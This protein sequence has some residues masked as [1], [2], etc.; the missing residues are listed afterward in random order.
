MK[1]YMLALFCFVWIQYNVQVVNGDITVELKLISYINKQGLKNDK[2]CCD[3]GKNC[4]SNPCDPEITGCLS[5]II[6]SANCDIGRFTTK[7]YIDQNYISFGHTLGLNIINPIIFNYENEWKNSINV[8]LTVKDIDEGNTHDIIDTFHDEIKFVKVYSTK[9]ESIPLLRNWQG[10]VSSIKYAL[11]IYCSNNYYGDTCSTFCFSAGNQQYECNRNG[12]KVCKDNWYGDKCDKFCMEKDSDIDGH[13]RCDKNGDKIC[14]TNWYTSNCTVHCKENNTSTYKCSVLGDKKCLRFW[15]GPQCDVYCNP[16]LL[17]SGYYTCDAST[18]KKICLANWFG[19][20][21]SVFCRE[22]VKSN[23]ICNSYTGEK[24][25]QPNYYGKDCENYCKEEVGSNY[26]CNDNGGKKCHHHF[27]G[28]DC[29]IYVPSL[30]TSE[31][32]CVVSNSFFYKSF[33]GHF[34]TFSGG[35]TYQLT[36]D[37]IDNTFAVHLFTEPNCMSLSQSCKHSVNIYFGIV[38]IKLEHNNVKV[39]NDSISLP[40]VFKNILFEKS[41]FNYVVISGW[42]GVT[43]KWDGTS[44]YIELAASYANK[45]CGLCGNFNGNPKDDFTS[46]QGEMATSSET[47]ANSW[48]RLRLGEVCSKSYSHYGYINPV[49]N[50]YNQLPVVDKN[51]VTQICSVLYSLKFQRCNGSVDPSTFYN[52]CLED[53]ASCN[54]PFGVNCSCQALTEYSRTCAE[55]NVVLQWR[56][57]SLCYRSCPRDMIYSECDSTCPRTCKIKYQNVP[58]INKCIDGCVC[59][60]GYVKYN[61]TCILESECPCTHNDKIYQKGETIQKD[62][63]KC[64]CL[65]GRWNCT[66]NVCPGTCATYGDPHYKTFDGKW[67]DFNGICKYVLAQDWETHLFRVTTENIAC[68][69]T[70]DVSCA[71][72]VT[73]QLNGSVIV[74]NQGMKVAVEKKAVLLP[75]TGPGILIRK[76]SSMFLKVSTTIGLEILFDGSSRIYVTVSPRF[77]NKTRGLCGTFNLNQK[78]DFMTPEGIINKNEIAFGNAWKFGTNCDPVVEKRHPCEL[79]TQK[80]PVASKKCRKMLLSPFS[81]CH[82][83]VLPDP[84]IEACRFDV[85]GCLDGVKCLCNAVAAYTKACADKGVKIN[86][87]NEEIVSECAISCPTGRTYQECGNICHNKCEDLVLETNCNEKCIAG[88]NCPNG[89]LENE[90]GSCVPIS[91]CSCNHQGNSYP[92]GYVVYQEKCKKCICANGQLKCE[93]DK[94]CGKSKCPGN[95]VWSDV[96]VECLKTCETLHLPCLNQLSTAGCHCSNGTIWDSLNNKCVDALSCPCHYNGRAYKDGETYS[97]DCNTCT[98]NNNKWSCTANICPGTCSV[99]GDPHYTTFDGKRFM[100]EGRCDY[101]I[102]QDFCDGRNGTFRIQAENIPCGNSGS[103]CTKSIYFTFEDTILHLQKDQ[104][105]TALPAPNHNIMTA[106]YD[107]IKTTFF[108]IIHTQIGITVLWDRGTRIL[109]SLNP[110]YKGSTCGL[111]GNFNDDQNDDFTTPE[112]DV[113]VNAASFG[114]SWKVND[115]CPDT[116]P[117][118]HPC[119]IHKSRAPWSHKQ[120]NVINREVFKPCHAVVNPHPYFDACYHDACGCDMGGDCECLC[121]AVSAYAEACNAQG[122][123]IKWRSQ[124]LCPIQCEQCQEYKPCGSSNPRT[125]RN[126]CTVQS[127]FP[128]KCVEGCVCSNDTVLHNGKCIKQAECPCYHDN[129]EHKPGSFIIINCQ[130]CTCKDGCL[131]CTGQTCT[132]TALPPT[133]TPGSTSSTSSATQTS[134]PTT[135]STTTESTT[136]GTTAGSTTSRPTTESTKL[137]TTAGST[138]P[139]TTIE[140]TTTS[141]TTTKS[142]TPSTSTEST[143][144]S[145]I[146]TE[147]T[148]TSSSTKSTLSATTVG[149]TKTTTATHETSTPTQTTTSSSTKSRSTSPSSTLSTETSTASKTKPPTTTQSSTLS[150]SSTQSKTTS[151]STETITDRPSTPTTGS[152]T[153]SSTSKATSQTTPEVTSSST[154]TSTSVTKK[155]STSP[156]T[157]PETTSTSTSLT[158][159][160]SSTSSTQSPTTTETS[161]RVLSTSKPTVTKETTLSTR[162]STTLIRACRIGNEIGYEC[163]NSPKFC[164]E[165]ERLCDG[166][167]NCPEF[168]D[169]ENCPTK[170]PP[171]TTSPWNMTTI[172]PPKT[173][174]STTPKACDGF[175][176]NT[177]FCIRKG[178]VCDG[179]ADCPGEEDEFNCPSTTATST[180]TTTTNLPTESTTGS[181]KRPST[182]KET[183]TTTVKSSSTTSSSTSSPLTSLPST[184]SPSTSSFTTSS[185]TTSST[186]PS[187]TQTST[188]K[189]T[190]PLEC[191]LSPYK[192][193]CKDKSNCL[194]STQICDNKIDCKD[195]SDE[196]KCPT[197]CPNCSRLNFKCHKTCQC[198]PVEYVCDGKNDCTDESDELGCPKISTSTSPTTFPPTTTLTTLPPTTLPPCP[199]NKIYKPCQRNCQGKCTFLLDKCIESSRSCKPGCG[200]PQGLVGNGTF[201]VLPSACPCYDPVLRQYFRAEQNWNR[202]S[203]EICS[204]FNDAVTCAKKPCEKLYCVPPMTLKTKPGDCCPTCVAGTF[205]PTTLATTSKPTCLLSEFLC[206]NGQCIPKHWVCDDERDCFHADDERNCTTKKP[207]CFAPIGV[208]NPSIIKASAF[209]SSSHQY[210]IRGPVFQASNARLNHREKLNVT[211]GA[212]CAN[213]YVSGIHWISVDLGQIYTVNKIAVQSRDSAIAFIRNFK[214]KYSINQYDFQYYKLHGNVK[215]FSGNRR[216]NQVVYRKFEHAIQARVIRLEV[217]KYYGRPCLRFELYGCIN[218]SLTTTPPPTT[219]L[220]TFRPTTV[221]SEFECQ[222]GECIA[223]R[224]VC[225][226]VANCKDGS[227]EFNCNRTCGPNEFTCESGQ[228]TLSV[229]VCDG[230]H[231]CKDGSDEWYCP[232]RTC[233]PSQFKCPSG[234]CIFRTYVCDGQD[235]CPSGADEKNCTDTT[236]TVLPSTTTSTTVVTTTTQCNGFIC[237]SSKNCIDKSW[238]CDK[239]TDCMNQEDEKCCSEELFL[240]PKSLGSVLGKC[241]KRT[242][243]CDNYLDCEDG[244]DEKNCSITTT[245]PTTTIKTQIVTES[246]PTT[247]TGGVKRST[248]TT[249]ATTLCPRN[250]T[251][252]CINTCNSLAKDPRGCHRLQCIDACSCPKYFKYSKRTGYCHS[253]P[254]CPCVRNGKVFVT[255]SVVDQANCTKCV[256]TPSG[257]QCSKY[258]NISCP[259]GHTLEYPVNQCCKCVKEL[260]CR[261][262]QVKTSCACP[263]TCDDKV[264]TKCTSQ[265]CKEGCVC[266]KGKYDNGTHCIDVTGCYCK[267]NNGRVRKPNSY[268]NRGECEECKCS[269]GTISCGLLCKYT[270][271]PINF[272]LIKPKNGCCKCVA[273]KQ[274]TTIPFTTAG[275][276]PFTTGSTTTTQIVTNGTIAPLKQCTLLERSKHYTDRKTNCKAEYPLIIS[277]CM[278]SCN[279]TVASDFTYGYSISRCSC[280]RPSG[281]YNVTVSLKCATGMRRRL[282]YERFNACYCQPCDRSPFVDVPLLTISP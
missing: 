36:A 16:N 271:C 103:T 187:T 62:C 253:D 186:S 93:N 63:N 250:S 232:N 162:K 222:N 226:N 175:L 216:V 127:E 204:C 247:V 98:C 267:E 229:N 146:T 17:D 116:K 264:N 134:T 40:Y 215:I 120:C 53:V 102:S 119:S 179:E 245:P 80:E 61:S 72:S 6:N 31:A 180:T 174:A 105:M 255:G 106:K 115:R 78:D 198:T 169:E 126:I 263:V 241:I 164:I 84:Y 252:L 281:I 268:W 196:D 166:V 210:T 276:T 144:K 156:S 45:T 1:I 193:I 143:T 225:N 97:W 118:V 282:T 238:I 110:K 129:M 15:Y 121:T 200:C 138:T 150:T 107:V 92:A 8:Q 272:E 145:W 233:Q 237:P 35:C 191:V 124:Q 74:L 192:V 94:L 171:P 41:G 219:T 39:N 161:T 136:L 49:V 167:Y 66:T 132:S 197:L 51:K 109:I 211:A 77:R 163:R 178:M 205:Q 251:C 199:N 23:Y 123:H 279:S 87:R 280:C 3:S 130:E 81:A 22:D 242:Y 220:S 122:V 266:P 42:P 262:D 85:C 265:N 114:D 4:S 70:K 273:I 278:G 48:K 82:N 185:S 254:K 231:D 69:T 149:E 32:K 9:S 59:P 213:I 47:F 194:D 104:P 113:V 137:G 244:Y 30:P 7:Q 2:E 5:A 33:D 214:L 65:S 75:Y 260:V 236:T 50:R 184:S 246:G 217:V 277:M 37:C 24:R 154:R 234:K 148:T 34:F 128:V 190:T 10:K 207:Y 189:A 177:N 60:S 168:E 57:Q 203:C 20:N 208:A 227:D 270:T 258:C 159:R 240:C 257:I 181:T 101:L 58:C 160:E 83:I 91:Q 223:N 111:C 73:L 54:V 11:Q 27:Y 100:F 155:T 25:C 112:L 195:G 43:I 275:T 256:C 55:K 248:Q 99:Y 218:T 79:Q 230:D 183:T 125:C 46:S 108:D 261:A 95:Q 117:S 19:V 172:F 157:T 18:G 90:L 274:T 176:C 14:Y 52:Q 28:K 133:T 152:T 153:P 12:S 131:Q 212:W 86:W 243:V 269:S 249:K 235:D 141:R 44:V 170:P 68:S 26:T 76:V 147:S 224:L 67:F 206:G 139:G 173:T 151:S 228:C 140:S 209:A 158:S 13:Y 21:C 221:C 38:N 239:V 88:C 96:G 165:R 135:S 259:V 71:K 29:S 201:C 56:S 202:T 89:T 142:K 188:T 182:S 64:L